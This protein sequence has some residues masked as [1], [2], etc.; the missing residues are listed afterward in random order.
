MLEKGGRA[1]P[2]FPAPNTAYVSTK[3]SLL[4]R[5]FSGKQFVPDQFEAFEKSPKVRSTMQMQEDRASK[6]LTI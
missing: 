3:H 1:C 2:P 6:W 5:A 4:L